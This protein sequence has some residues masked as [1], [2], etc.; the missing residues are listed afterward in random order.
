MRRVQL[1]LYPAGSVC[2]GS[3]VVTSMMMYSKVMR[4]SARIFRVLFMIEI[5]GFWD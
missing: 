3:A 4:D 1:F 2:V 5:G